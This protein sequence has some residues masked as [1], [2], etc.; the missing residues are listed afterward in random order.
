MS[1]IRTTISLESEV[2]DQAKATYGEL[3]Y[4]KMGDLINEALREY[5]IRQRTVRK[6]QAMEEAARDEDYLTVLRE[7]GEDFEQ[8]DAE[9]LPDY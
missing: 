5:L 2:Y 9:G 1:R 8:V 3:G 7:I 6:D 4:R